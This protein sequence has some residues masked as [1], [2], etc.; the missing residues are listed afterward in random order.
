MRA[1]VDSEGGTRSRP[2]SRT[3]MQRVASGPLE[4]ND[5]APDDDQAEW[6]KQEQQV[7]S[8]CFW[9]LELVN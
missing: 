1:E 9:F 3:G 7:R 6:A 2:L 8:H 5:E 4:S